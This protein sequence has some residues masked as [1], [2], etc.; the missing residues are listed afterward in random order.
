[1]ESNGTINNNSNLEA[2]EEDEDKDPKRKLST[3]VTASMAVKKL[4]ND[5]KRIQEFKKNI[6]IMRRD[7]QKIDLHTVSEKGDYEN[8]KLL[9]EKKFDPNGRNELYKTPLHLACKSLSPKVIELLL[10]NGANVKA[11]SNTKYNTN[12]KWCCYGSLVMVT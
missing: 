2:I 3:M 6:T 9:L 4:Q 11:L 8:V 12:N 7:S 10:E 1:M 5:Q